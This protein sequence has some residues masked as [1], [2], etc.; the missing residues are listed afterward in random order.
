M[1]IYRL[2]RKKYGTQLSGKGASIG[3]GR[4]NSKNT[5][6]IYC[7]ESR[8]LAM[9]EVIVH[10]EIDTAPTYAMLSIDIPKSIKVK[11]VA[12]NS[13]PIN[14]SVFPH[15]YQ[16]QN[17]GDKFIAVNKFCLLKVP[18]A[19]VHGDYNIL[20]NPFHKDFSKIKV[21]DVANFPLDERL[22]G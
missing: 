11:E 5:E 6:I 1:N 20:I 16:T 14:W 13:L 3:G 17:V 12:T 10:I 2:Q 7:A 22:F 19:I 4:W 9:A 21:V 18:S 8:A 15:Q